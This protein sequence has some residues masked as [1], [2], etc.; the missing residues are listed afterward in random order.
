MVSDVN[1]LRRSFECLTHFGV[2]TATCSFNDEMTCY[3]YT[4]YAA[5]YMTIPARCEVWS[6][7][8]PIAHLVKI[9]VT[10]MSHSLVRL[11]FFTKYLVVE[12]EVKYHVQYV[13]RVSEEL[14]YPTV[15]SCAAF[16]VNLPTLQRFLKLSD[17]NVELRAEDGLTFVS[18]YDKVIKSRVSFPTFEG[19]MLLRLN[20]PLA[21]QEP[22]AEDCRFST[23]L[24]RYLC[25]TQ[26]FQT[27]GVLVVCRDH[28]VWQSQRNDV[29]M[30]VCFTCYD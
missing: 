26:S 3:G 12:N 17:E 24:L 1:T 29:D 10:C 16:Q 7:C 4:D 14:V 5:I 20:V 21:C 27:S 22:W 13:D 11:Q 9:L 28:I 23:I 30:K 2:A 8:I 19:P 18:T 15:R 25:R 6:C